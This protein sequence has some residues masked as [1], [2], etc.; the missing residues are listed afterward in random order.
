[1]NPIDR[2]VTAAI[3][4]WESGKISDDNLDL[5][6]VATESA[7]VVLRAYGANWVSTMGLQTTLT[8]MESARDSRQRDDA[9]RRLVSNTESSQP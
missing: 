2:K 8:S 6:I 7:L 9:K 5:A 1:M 3:R 4:E